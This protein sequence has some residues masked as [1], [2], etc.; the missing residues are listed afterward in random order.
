MID[1]ILGKLVADKYRIESLIRESS[2]GDLFSARHEVLDKP[3]TVK[4]LPAALAI[5]S[6]WV[7][8]FVAEARSAS[9]LSHQNILNI[10]DFGTDARGVSYAVYEPA[11]DKTLSDLLNDDS[12]IDEKR[13]VVLAR[14]IADAVSAAHEKGVIHG[15]LNPQN[16]FIGGDDAVKVYGFGG[17]PLRFPRDADPRYQ[18]PEQCSAFPTADR[19]ADIYS[20]GVMLFEMLA[21]AVPFVGA[22]AADVLARQNSEPPPPLSAFRRD[23]HP[24]IEPIILSSLAFDPE[25]RYPTMAAF[26]EDLG[27]VSSGETQLQTAAA[28]AAGNG[29][30]RNIWQ[31]AFIVLAGT[32]LLAGAFIYATSAR[33]TD[34]TAQLQPEPGSLPVQP[35][36][37]ATGAQE[38]SLAKLPAMTDAEVMAATMGQTPDMVPGG[39]G[40]N[41]WA[42]GGIPP[43]G[44]PL[45]QGLPP[46]GLPPGA[47]VQ[48]GGQ[49]YTVDPNGSQFMPPDSGVILVPVPANSNTAT[50]KPSAT[51]KSANVAIGQPSPTPA[52]TQKPMATPP[53]PDKPAPTPA[54]KDKPPPAAKPVK[55]PNKPAE[56]E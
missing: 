20:V 54:G 43:A 34:P 52:P 53:G 49:Y 19:R 29:A 15:S 10:T 8:R 3:V 30:K 18:A 14:N 26:A 35:I 44:A 41:A 17:E 28:A 47:Y 5:D 25:K 36:G 55:S 2:S 27:R 38:E 56:S 7:K 22:T 31:T 45:N 1:D 11:G 46:T 51:P 33:K 40:Y 32:L 21:G 23:L 4:I 42:K 12:P 9:T 13:A 37:P 16:V 6:R 39:D 24:E 50:P 48:P